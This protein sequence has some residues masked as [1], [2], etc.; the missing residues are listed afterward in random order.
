MMADKYYKRYIDKLINSNP[1]IIEISRYKKIDDGYGGNDNQDLE[2][3]EKVCFYEM[4]SR[5]E[6]ITDYGKTYTGVN[7][8]KILAKGD[9]D[10]IK[11]DLIKDATNEYKVL[12][13]R[14]YKDICKQIELEVIK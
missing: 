2:I 12:F 11:G 1:T 9:A 13:V 8:S 10:I 7:V 4:K 14:G 6:V 3:T 5:R